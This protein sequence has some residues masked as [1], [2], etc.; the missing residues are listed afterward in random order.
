MT[1]VITKQVTRSIQPCITQEYL[2]PNKAYIQTRVTAKEAVM[3]MYKKC[4]KLVE[5]SMFDTKPVQYIIMISDQLK[6]VV[7]E[8]QR[9]NLETRKV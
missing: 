3:E 2:K 5:A 8:K 7:R 6:L 9:L 4:T 1:C